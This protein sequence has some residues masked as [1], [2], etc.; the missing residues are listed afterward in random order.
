MI[1]KRFHK[2]YFGAILKDI[3][4]NMEKIKVD[5]Y[6]LNI[7]PMSIQHL[8]TLFKIICDKDKSLTDFNN[9]ELVELIEGIRKICADNGYILKIDDVEW[10]RLLRYADCY[11]SN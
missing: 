8:H 6:W 7:K 11:I 3:K 1:S 9:K 5:N 10:E 2:F 4:N